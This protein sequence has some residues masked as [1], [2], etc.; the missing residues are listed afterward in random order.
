MPRRRSPLGASRPAERALVPPEGGATGRGDRDRPV[1]A[2]H[3]RAPGVGLGRPPGR[4]SHPAGW[5]RPGAHRAGRRSRQPVRLHTPRGSARR[6]GPGR[7]RGGGIRAHPVADPAG[8]QPGAAGRSRHRPL[9]RG[10]R[11]LLQLPRRDRRTG[12]PAGRRDRGG[13]RP[14]GLGS[15]RRPA[16]GGA[17]G[18]GGGFPAVQLGTGHRVP[19]RQRQ[20]FPWIHS[21]RAPAPRSA[22]P[23]L[24]GSG[25]RW[26]EPVAVPGRR[27]VDARRPRPA[28]RTPLRGAP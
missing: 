11:E 13:H 1:G 12:R 15:V 3:T 24:A 7:A 20:L 2:R 28:R 25:L 10:G 23:A 9:D 14:R 27:D 17:G 6:R 21:R 26:C 18:S 8:A 19:G 22:G 16:G 4:D 5:R